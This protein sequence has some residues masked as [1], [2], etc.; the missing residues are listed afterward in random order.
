[1][2]CI[3]NMHFSEYDYF[4]SSTAP[5]AKGTNAKMDSKKAYAFTPLP[6]LSYPLLNLVP[7]F[8]E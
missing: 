5:E 6:G 2:S 4:I 7:K 8:I 3:I 1:M